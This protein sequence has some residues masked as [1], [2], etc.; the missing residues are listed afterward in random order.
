VLVGEVPAD[1]VVDE[2]GLHDRD[3]GGIV[4]HNVQ[5]GAREIVEDPGDLL[6]AV[7]GGGIAR[8]G[9]ARGDHQGARGQDRDVS[10]VSSLLRC[11]AW[12]SLD[13]WTARLR[14]RM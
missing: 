10:H 9:D 11:A 1:A 4:V 7:D 6:D 2:I 5:R 3:A 14:G 12:A 8:K 13:G